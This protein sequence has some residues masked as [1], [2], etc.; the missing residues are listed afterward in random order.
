L[1]PGLEKLTYPI[2]KYE[3]DVAADLLVNIINMM[4]RVQKCP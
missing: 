4:K 3:E 1:A 2:L